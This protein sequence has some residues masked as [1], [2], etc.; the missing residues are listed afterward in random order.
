MKYDILGGFRRWLN[1][2]ES[3]TNK[4]T[5]DRYY[6]AVAKLLRQMQFDSLEEIP[7]ESL[8]DKLAALRTKND[9]SAAKNGLKLLEQYDK[10]LTLPKDAFFRQIS[11]QKRNRTKTVDTAARP[12]D[13]VRRVNALRDKKLKLAYRL[14]LA[15][16]L[17]VFEVAALTAGDIVISDDVI[18]VHVQHGKGGKAANVKSM[19]DKYLAENLARFL[20][21]KAMQEFVFYSAQYMKNKAWEHNLECHDMRRIAAV[22]FHE[23]Q[24]E[25]R[26]AQ[27]IEQAN[28]ETQEFLRHERFMTTKRYL[29]SPRLLSEDHRVRQKERKKAAAT[30][31]N[32]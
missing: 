29:N 1:E 21:G 17:R 4:N 25:K 15:T 12:S 6:F 27:A 20:E 24:I 18:I 28:L 26:T 7:P 8:L 22:N 23:K 14:M 30:G 5:A 13:I 19:P 3:V 2:S 31:E 10:T 32:L 11:E 16:G 9:V